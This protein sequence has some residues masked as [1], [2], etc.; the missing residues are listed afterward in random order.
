MTS[1][2][3]ERKTLPGPIRR[4]LLEERDLMQRAVQARKLDAAAGAKTGR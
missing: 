3:L 4:I 1:Q 2:T